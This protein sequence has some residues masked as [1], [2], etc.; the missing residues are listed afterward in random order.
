MTGMVKYTALSV[1]DPIA[2]AVNAAGSG[3]FWLR[4]VIKLGAIAG[5]TSVILVLLLGQTR[6]FYS[7]SSDGLVPPA[8]SKVHP[9]FKTP[10][11]TT[12]VMGLVAMIF[13]GTLPIQLLGEL[14]SIGTLL[15][16]VIVCVG[17]IVLRHTHPEYPRAFKTPWVPVVP[18]LGALLSLAQ[19]VSLPLGTWVRLLVWMTIGIM[20]YFTY[21]RRHS[22][23]QKLAEDLRG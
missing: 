22:R 4:P 14:V 8:F 5:L 10:Y 18:I 2:V 12:L 15:A 7:V 3:L 1:P 21:G 20:I 11:I 16:F 23:V 9:R 13:S 17:I 19:M 6:I